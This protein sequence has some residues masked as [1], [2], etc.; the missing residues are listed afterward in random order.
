MALNRDQHR[1]LRLLADAPNG[2]SATIM[3][4]RG[5]TISLLDDLVLR[6]LDGGKARHARGAARLSHYKTIRKRK[7]PTM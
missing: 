4:A 6:G 3:L 2:A 5:F 7:A 1:A